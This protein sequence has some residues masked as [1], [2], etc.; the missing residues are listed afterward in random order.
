MARTETD[1]YFVK[2]VGDGIYIKDEGT[3]ETFGLC[4]CTEYTNDDNPANVTKERVICDYLLNGLSTLI[5]EAKHIH[6]IEG[7]SG[8]ITSSVTE[9]SKATQ[10]T[11]V[12]IDAD[13]ANASSGTSYTAENVG[14]PVEKS[15]AI[16]MVEKLNNGEPF[17]P[18]Q[19]EESMKSGYGKELPFLKVAYAGLL[20]HIRKTGKRKFNV[21]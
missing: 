19:F 10:S 1:K 8:W 13:L 2:R 17:D 11:Y 20:E 5:I 15:E 9:K 7:S 21:Q 4:P 12:I 14:D 6:Q 3:E 16:E 18:P